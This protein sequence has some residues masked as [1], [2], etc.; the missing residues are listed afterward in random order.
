MVLDFN[1]V[2]DIFGMILSGTHCTSMSNCILRMYV[3]TYMYIH[4]HIISVCV[5]GFPGKVCV[6]YS[7]IS[8]DVLL[9]VSS[10]SLPSA[11][12]CCSSA[13]SYFLM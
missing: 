10:T 7:V 2:N 8:D 9:S 1:S 11:M 12:L 3:G 13:G 4:V 5:S 6:L